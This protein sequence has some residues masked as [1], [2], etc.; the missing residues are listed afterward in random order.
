MTLAAV[1]F[2]LFALLSSAGAYW[3][4]AH[5]RSRAVGAG[6]ALAV[7]A[8]FALLALG[9]FWLVRSAGA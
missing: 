2:V 3:A 5:F 8:F 6:L 9:I 1:L 7:A 4:G